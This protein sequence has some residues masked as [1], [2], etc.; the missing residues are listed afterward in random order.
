MKLPSGVASGLHSTVLV[1]SDES[2]G[3]LSVDVWSLCAVAALA[4]YEVAAFFSAILCSIFHPVTAK[5]VRI[6]SVAVTP[7]GEKPR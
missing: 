2:G 7:M 4:T 5:R 1:G 6:A 3:V